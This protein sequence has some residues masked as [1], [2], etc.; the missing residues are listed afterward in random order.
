MAAATSLTFS[1][2]SSSATTMRSTSAGLVSRMVRSSRSISLC[3]REGALLFTA[4]PW[5]RRQ[6]LSRERSSLESTD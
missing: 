2:A 1:K 4:Q 3:S 5:M 6:V